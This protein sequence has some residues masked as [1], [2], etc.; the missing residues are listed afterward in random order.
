MLQM[1][2]S[3]TNS[4]KEESQSEE[5]VSMNGLL[6]LD[7]FDNQNSSERNYLELKNQ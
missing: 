1:L 3:N 2:E 7:A 5:E 6:G 4:F